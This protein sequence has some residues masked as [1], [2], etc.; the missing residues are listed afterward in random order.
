MC[1]PVLTFRTST[2][3][4]LEIKDWIMVPVK[5]DCGAASMATKVTKAANCM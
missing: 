4:V 5:G 2:W 1:H 3:G